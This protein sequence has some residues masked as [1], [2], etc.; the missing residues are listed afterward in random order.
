MSI[1]Q[2]LTKL[3]NSRSVPP[4]SFRAVAASIGG[5]DLVEEYLAA[6]FWPLTYGWAAKSFSKVKLGNLTHP[7]FYPQFGLER[8]ANSSNEVVVVAAHA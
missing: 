1:N 3:W 4:D 2:I 8:P 5:Y 7:I 6:K